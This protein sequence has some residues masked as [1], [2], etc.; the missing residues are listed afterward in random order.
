MKSLSSYLRAA[1]EEAE[2]AP[3]TDAPP[4]PTGPQTTDELNKVLA[5]YIE[6]AEKGLNGLVFNKVLTD[7]LHFEV[8]A[9]ETLEGADKKKALAKLAAAKK[10]LKPL[11]KEFAKAQA[12][13]LKLVVKA[14]AA[15]KKL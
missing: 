12:G 10:I 7:L 13:M 2:N 3:A 4:E 8:H 1:A 11:S 15:I 14:K 5:G 9:K 6:N